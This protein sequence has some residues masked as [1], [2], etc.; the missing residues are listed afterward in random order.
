MLIICSSNGS[1]GGSSSNVVLE[2]EV[3]LRPTTRSCNSSSTS[4]GRQRL[5]LV[6]YLVMPATNTAP[7]NTI[8][9]TP[10]TRTEFSNACY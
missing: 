5:Q 6:R 7:I 1:S 4:L 3:D 9:P 8:T 10:T 2:V